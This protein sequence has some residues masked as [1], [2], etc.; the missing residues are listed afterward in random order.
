MA[1]IELSQ[2]SIPAPPRIVRPKKEPAKAYEA[3]VVYYELG[4][5]RTFTK[6][7]EKTGKTPDNY[8]K[9][10]KRWWWDERIEAQAEDARVAYKEAIRV[11]AQEMADKVLALRLE[12]LELQLEAA[13][14][15]QAKADIITNLPVVEKT[16]TK[17]SPDGRTQWITIKPV[18]VR[19]TDGGRLAL[20]V[21]KLIRSLTE[22]T[23]PPEKRVENGADGTRKGRMRAPIVELFIDNGDGTRGK[24]S[25]QPPPDVYDPA[26]DFADDEDGDPASFSL[27]GAES[28]P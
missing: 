19:A 13:K 2:P 6:L 23:A 22:Q 16:I 4:E 12:V 8:R 20:M 24:M 28:A 3:F 10:A 14:A 1:G 21:D 27:G 17:T 15:L 18:G 26:N 25:D 5:A 9:T 11:R 7:S